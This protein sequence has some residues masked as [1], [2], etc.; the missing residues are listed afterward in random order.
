MG[1]GKTTVYRMIRRGELR[2]SGGRP[3]RVRRADLVE[4]VARCRV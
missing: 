2:V 1:L 4:H 3:N